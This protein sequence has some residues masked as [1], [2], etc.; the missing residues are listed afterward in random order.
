[1]PG[2]FVDSKINQNLEIATE[3]FK[4]LV[5][6][7]IRDKNL[8]LKKSAGSIGFIPFNVSFTM[9]GLSGIKI[10]NELSV[11]TNFLPKGYTDTTNFIVTGVD[12]KIQNGDWETNVKL[13]L[14]PTTEP[15][16][17]VITSSISITT[18]VEEAPKVPPTPGTGEKGRP[19]GV[20]GDNAR[21]LDSDLIPILT[22]NGQTYRLYKEAATGYAA[23]KAGAAAAGYDLDTALSSAYR[24]YAKQESLYNTYLA[25]G[26]SFPTAAPGTSNHG[27]GRS[28]D[29]HT[30]PS[31]IND[32]LRKNCVKYNWYW[33]GPAD[34]IHFTY[35]FNE[36]EYPQL[37]QSP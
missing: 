2:H 35:G 15:I 29:I 24:E 16:T 6:N 13:T 25:G 18:P 36:S 12:H 17:D 5:S 34:K 26:S 22:K 1:M 31:S 37:P 30:S 7:K 10:Y 11:D 19:P 3:Y 9:D 27:W 33:F 32:W 8:K 21:L 20:I 4:A 28:I 23:L 14:I